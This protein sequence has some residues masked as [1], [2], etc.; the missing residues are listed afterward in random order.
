MPQ[1]YDNDHKVENKLQRA[2]LKENHFRT[3]Y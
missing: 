3:L 1:V 2:Y